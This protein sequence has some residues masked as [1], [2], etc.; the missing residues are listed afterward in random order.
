MTEKVEFT[1]YAESQIQERDIKREDVLN[2]VR[3]P[4]QI[5]PAKKGRKVAQKIIERNG[6]KGL[7][8]VIFEEKVNAKV[9]ITV[10]WTSKIKKYWR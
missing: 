5:L 9:V 1:T 4:G 2:T 8:R 3:F 10:Y 7:L 6:Q